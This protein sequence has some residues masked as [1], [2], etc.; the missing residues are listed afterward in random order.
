MASPRRPHTTSPALAVRTA[1]LLLL[2]L[3]SHD[4]FCSFEGDRCGVA[5]FSSVLSLMRPAGTCKHEPEVATVSSAVNISYGDLAGLT[6]AVAT[7]GPVSVVSHPQPSP[8]SAAWAVTSSECVRGKNMWDEWQAIDVNFCWQF[9]QN[10][11]VFCA[12]C[13]RLTHSPSL[14]TCS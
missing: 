3:L 1:L 14:L 4:V 9:Y 6:A 5:V 8:S 10:G 11:S 7:Q 12:S 2:L 13:R